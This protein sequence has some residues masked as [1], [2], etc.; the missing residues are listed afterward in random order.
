MS[1]E[2]NQSY[3]VSDRRIA[4]EIIRLFIKALLE[5]S[6]PDGDDG[7]RKLRISGKLFEE[8]KSIVPAGKMS[9]EDINVWFERFKSAV[10]LTQGEVN[11][12]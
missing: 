3:S 9:D 11:N 12:A 7:I 8:W 10:E 4:Y 2:Q 1:V 6:V 5:V